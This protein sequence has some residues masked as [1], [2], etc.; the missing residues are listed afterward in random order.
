MSYRNKFTGNSQSLHS[1]FN[2]DSEHLHAIAIVY[3]KSYSFPE[4]SD[5]FQIAIN[6]KKPFININSEILEI[7]KSNLVDFIVYA[8]KSP[9][10]NCKLFTDLYSEYAKKEYILREFGNSKGS[11]KDR[12]LNRFALDGIAFSPDKYKIGTPTPGKENDCNGKQF[13]FLDQFLAEIAI[14]I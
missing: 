1:L 10:D 6:S 7:I 14:S 11:G 3:K 8:S 2:K 4:Y 5:K 13:F 9:Y 12:T